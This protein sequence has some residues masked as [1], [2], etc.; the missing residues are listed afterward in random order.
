MCRFF[1]VPEGVVQTGSGKTI[2]E[3]EDNIF[4]QE[5]NADYY[6][7]PSYQRSFGEKLSWVRKYAPYSKSLLD[8]G[9]NFG[10]FLHDAGEYYNATGIEIS[11]QAVSW[12]RDKFG[13]NN[14]ACSLYTPPDDLGA[15][16]DIVT[17]WDVIE[18]IADPIGALQ[19]FHRLIKPGGFLFLSTPDAGSFLARTMQSNW[20]YL[21]PIQ[22][23]SLFDKNNLSLLLR[24]SGFKPLAW[25]HFGHFYRVK[26]LQERMR[27]L[28][29]QDAWHG[30]IKIVNDIT[31]P[32]SNLMLYLKLWDV[33]GVVAVRDEI[34]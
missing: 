2:Y 17:S 26:Y 20:H 1:F 6:F 28:H 19:V 22:H 33:M 27:Y 3:D 8:A 21:D 24:Q 12:S 25:R 15:P 4:G 32:F 13:V 14:H 29:K 7:D 31:R 11:P 16:F 18:H 34:Q 23:I 9:A 5:G 30:L 10:H